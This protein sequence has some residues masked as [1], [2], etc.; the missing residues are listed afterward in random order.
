MYYAVLKLDNLTP[1]SCLFC[2]CTLLIVESIY[3]SFEWTARTT[4]MQDQ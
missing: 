3:L 4:Y 1:N 2:F